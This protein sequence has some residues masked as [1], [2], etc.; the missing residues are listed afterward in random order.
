MKLVPNFLADMFGKKSM[1]T[2]D[3]YREIYGGKK[4]SSGMVVSR[5]TAL[6]LPTVF[7]CLRVIG[8]GRA[9]IPLK[10]MQEANGKRLPAR[11]HP[12][13]RLMALKPNRWQT[14]FEWRQM[15]SWHVELCGNHYSYINR[16]GDKIVELFPFMPDRVRY[17]D[18]GRGEHEYEVTAPNGAKEIFPSKSILHI[19][20]P[21]WDGQLGLD[22]LKAA[23]D[24][25]GLTMAAEESASTLHKNGISSSGTY[26]VSGTLN[27]DQHKLLTS[28]L[29]ENY[30]GPENRGKPV[31]LDRDAKFQPTQMTSIDA[32]ALETRKHQV[33]DVCRFFGLLPIM[34]GY[35]DK[36]ATYASSEQQFLAHVVHSMSP[37]WESDEQAFMTQLLTEKELEAG[38]YFDYVEE[39][40]IRGAI[41]DTKDVLLG[42]TN[43]GVMTPNEARA[44][45]DLNPD[46]D[47]ASDKLRI[48]A[49][50][51]GAVPASEPAA[52]AV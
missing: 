14:A 33:E 15:M 35:S 24:S 26:S 17:I 18:L 43:G 5:D 31:I 42:Y 44:K 52:P 49:N 6:M 20:G 40:M 39:G 45:L 2:L 48:P 50:I 19:K 8:N 51:T 4:S 36:A 22:L 47:P 34:V 7:A 27:K 25:L 11:E 32:Q 28:F 9:Q 41:K 13:Y 16:F 37:R 12:L 46:P 38:Y 10:L 21:T 30:G 3:L 1:N 29:E 23:R